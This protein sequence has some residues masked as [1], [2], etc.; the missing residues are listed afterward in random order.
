M[1]LII[2]AVCLQIYFDY[3][4]LKHDFWGY[5][6]LFLP[7]QVAIAAV[8]C[9]YWYFLVYQKTSNPDPTTLQPQSDSVDVT[10]QTITLEHLGRPHE[11]QLD[12]VW[13]IRGAGNYVEIESGEGKFLKRTT[14]KKIQQELPPYFY[15]CHR[16][17]IVNLKFVQAV[18][19]QSSGHAVAS[20]KNGQQVNISKRCKNIVKNQPVS[21]IS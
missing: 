12:N 6:V 14:L 20:L 16:S 4:Y 13:L 11:L 2:L 21:C 5:F 17:H 9:L 3:E 18:Q 7:R 1:P 19:N 10:R 15:Q 8:I